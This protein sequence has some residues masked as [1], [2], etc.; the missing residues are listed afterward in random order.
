M[1]AHKKSPEQLQ[2]RNRPRAVDGELA[3][4]IG[5]RLDPEPPEA[6]S[7]ELAAEWRALW[8]ADLAT[9][10]VESDVPALRRMFILRDRVE[11]FDD[12]ALEDGAVVR[13]STGQKTIHPLLKEA[14]ALR[15]QI[16]ALEDRFGLSPMAR[17]KLN[18][19]LGDAHASLDAMNKRIAASAGGAGNTERPDPRLTVIDTNTA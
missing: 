3:E 12:E 10:Y 6:I 2:R 15:S 17:L 16:L 19:S 4:L 7:A 13:G 9:E 14:D 11:K 5:K 1:P 18:I 8:A